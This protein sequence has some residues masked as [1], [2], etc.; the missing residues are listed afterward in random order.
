ML[1]HMGTR[2]IPYSHVQ[3]PPKDTMHALTAI[4]VRGEATPLDQLRNVAGCP[5]GILAL[6]TRCLQTDPVQRPTFPSIVDELQRIKGSVR[7]SRPLAQLRRA[8]AIRQTG[9]TSA[10][11]FI[12]FNANGTGPY[13]LVERV[14]DNVLVLVNGRLVAEG[15]PHALRELMDE[16]PRRIR[17][18]A[19]PT[20]ALGAALAAVDG[21]EQ[22]EIG[23]H[24]IVVETSDPTAVARALPQLAHD[25]GATI[26]SVEPTDEDLESVY[27]YLT[28]RARGV[29]R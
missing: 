12:T 16:R 4:I 24:A 18:A 26:A 17:I 1:A 14:A 11:T 28:Q 13:K 10:P 19:S 7:A 5:P 9:A 22:L 20:R 25:C 23:E 2:S 8:D 6:S 29:R 15:A 27:G 3:L 21:V